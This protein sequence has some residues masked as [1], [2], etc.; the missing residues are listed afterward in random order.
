MTIFIILSISILKR[1]KCWFCITNFLQQVEQLKLKSKLHM[2]KVSINQCTKTLQRSNCTSGAKNINEVLWAYWIMKKVQNIFLVKKLLVSKRW[3]YIRFLICDFS[4][5]L[6]HVFHITEACDNFS[7]N[8]FSTSK[9]LNLKKCTK[10]NQTTV[11][12]YY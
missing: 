9:G 5:I 1:L 2:D 12:Y 6:S 3:S 10:K 11:N 4:T 7:G 8:A